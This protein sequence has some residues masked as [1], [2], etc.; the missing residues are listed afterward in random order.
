MEQK[1]LLILLEKLEKDFDINIECDKY[2]SFDVDI[3]EKGVN[4][5]VQVKGTL[6]KEHYVQ[7]TGVEVIHSTATIG[8]KRWGLIV[9]YLENLLLVD[10]YF[11]EQHEIAEGYI[12]GKHFLEKKTTI[13]PREQAVFLQKIR[14]E[15][16]ELLLIE[17]KDSHSYKVGPY[18]VENHFYYWNGLLLCRTINNIDDGS[19]DYDKRLEEALQVDIIE[20]LGRLYNS[21][22]AIDEEKRVYQV[23]QLNDPA[24]IRIIEQNY[25]GEI[26]VKTAFTPNTSGYR[27]GG[28]LTELLPNMEEAPETFQKQIE[29]RELPITFNNFIVH[30]ERVLGES[31]PTF[32]N[33][34]W[35]ILE[36]N[37]EEYRYYDRKELGTYGKVVGQNG[38]SLSVVWETEYD[39]DPETIHYRYVRKVA[40]NPFVELKA[41]EFV[42]F[43]KTPIRGYERQR[44]YGWVI[45]K[46]PNVSKIIPC[47]NINRYLK[48][49]H[50]NSTRFYRW[51]VDDFKREF[52]EKTG[53]EMDFILVANEEV[54]KDSYSSDFVQYIQTIDTETNTEY[55]VIANLLRLSN[56][57]DINRDYF[58]ITASYLSHSGKLPF[59]QLML[60]L[61]RLICNSSY[62]TRLEKDYDTVKDFRDFEM[63]EWLTNR[64]N[65]EERVEQ[66]SIL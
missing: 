15:E 46:T 22:K 30:S 17:N 39:T 27:L 31:I 11:V 16:L 38:S 45:A 13:Y 4:A 9:E 6:I 21:N 52:L 55:Q 66:L 35:I 57:N 28:T 12:Y 36:S 29:L 25:E 20:G 47:D 10:K 61:T 64:L 58:T 62:D 7:L 5:T 59:N 8:A 37:P 18:T 42:S 1:G 48:E 56:I 14:T 50:D 44:G 23:Y 3:K 33:D 43:A 24:N 63:K 54:E 53:A 51:D 2:L 40:D 34:S 32:D 41:P 60:E 19:Y 49:S 26:K 65:A